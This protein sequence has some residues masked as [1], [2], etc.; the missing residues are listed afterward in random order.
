MT[1]SFRI[2]LICSICDIYCLPV[3]PCSLEMPTSIS[4]L[5]SAE[6]FAFEN[7]K[8]IVEQCNFM[9]GKTS[10]F[11]GKHSLAGV[12]QHCFCKKDFFKLFFLPQKGFDQECRFKKQKISCLSTCISIKSSLFMLSL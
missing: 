8:K 5:T 1:W 2:L 4:P 3:H 11:H 7:R 10:N 6:L 9:E 12:N